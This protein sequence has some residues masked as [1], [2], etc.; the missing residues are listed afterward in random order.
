[1]I[2]ISFDGSKLTY[3]QTMKLHSL[4]NQIHDITPI[5]ACID[6]PIEVASLVHN[7][8]PSY[9]IHGDL[10]TDNEKYNFV[11]GGGLVPKSGTSITDK[12]VYG[13]THDK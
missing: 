13:Q 4:I 3:E 8:K 5:Q 2:S 1:M 6:A 11:D 12:D 9:N 7:Y 10:I